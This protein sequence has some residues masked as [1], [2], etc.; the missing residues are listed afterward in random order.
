MLPR[1]ER[2]SY[3]KAAGDENPLAGDLARELRLTFQISAGFC[4]AVFPYN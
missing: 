4:S 1:E 3:W 2:V